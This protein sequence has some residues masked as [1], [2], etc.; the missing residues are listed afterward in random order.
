MEKLNKFLRLENYLQITPI[1][2]DFVP[3]HKS[4]MMGVCRKKNRTMGYETRYLLL[5]I[6]QLL[7]ARDPDYEFLVNVIPLEGGF[8]I[9]RENENNPKL[10]LVIITQQR[11]FELNFENEKECNKWT[12]S[13]NLVLSK[14]IKKQKYKKRV[15]NQEQALS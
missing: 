5:G 8:C 7:I 3:P 12:H 4:L 13:I 9:V 11:V 6:S 15:K 2:N 10:G 1:M 14:Q